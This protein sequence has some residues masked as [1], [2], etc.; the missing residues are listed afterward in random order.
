M[1][2]L[3]VGVAEA[4]RKTRQAQASAE[5]PHG[6]TTGAPAGAPSAADTEDSAEFVL[7][8]FGDDGTGATAARSKEGGGK[9]L[10][11]REGFGGRSTTPPKGRAKGGA[12][13]EPPK[14]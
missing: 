3:I 10:V 5:M 4:M 12:S 9:K 6:A 11:K 1:N 8:S 2:G 7:K 13:S 14:A